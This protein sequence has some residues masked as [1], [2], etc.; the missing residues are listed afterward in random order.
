MPRMFLLSLAT[1]S[2]CATHSWAACQVQQ[3]EIPV[4]IVD[5]RPIA[6]L[7]LNGTEVPMLV[8]SGAF[9]SMLSPATATQLN[10]TVRRLPDGTRIEGYTGRIE[11]RRTRVEK[12]G[13]LG[14]ELPNV[15]FIVGGNEI[16]A[17][18]MG[19][20]GRNILA[21]ADTEYDLAHGVVRLSFPKG[22]CDKTN[23]A[24]WAGGAP[25]I[26]VPLDPPTVRADSAIRVPV[27]INGIRALALMDTGAPSTSLTLRLARRAGIEPGELKPYGR[28]GGAGDGRATSWTSP[29]A[30]FELGEQKVANTVLQVD[31]TSSRSHDMLVGL[32]Y[33]L[34]HRIYVS[35]LQGR[36]YATWN[37]GPIFALAR[38]AAGDDAGRYAALPQE[39]AADDAD[40]L[41]RRG[42]AAIAA[43]NHQR[44]LEDLNRACA[45][46]PTNADYL[47]TRAR[48]HLA[49]RQPSLALADLN[50]ALQLD[51]ALSEARLRRARL[52]AALGERAPA[53]E[54]L[55]QLD[56]ALP[57]SSAR[58]ADMAQ[59]YASLD[60]PAA[61]LKQF[62][63]W[64]NAHPRD[65]RLASVLNGRCWLR[66]RLNLDLPLALQDCKDAVDKDDGA[67]AHH[68]SLG[69]LYLR[70]GDAAQA[71][72]AFDRALKLQA[73][74]S[75][76][77]FSLYGRA[78]ALVRLNDVEG[79]ERDLAAARKLRP[80]I[81]D[82]I[83]RQGFPSA[84]STPPAA[85]PGS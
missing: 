74:P 82:E 34:S 40:A 59:V 55:A 51:P 18:I 8:D 23:F 26:E 67:A 81:D 64:V 41:A 76:L 60:Q 43:G 14:A 28:V 3:M 66:T 27:G 25:V 84:R 1:L 11:A 22:D 47:D 83:R 70:M 30:S 9:F 24:H 77:P 31:D 21:M 7:I 65:A 58:R 57:P 13:L 45:L 71:Q 49:M 78:M 36:M 75:A 80:R 50:Q 69:W 63:L 20:L 56:Q 62:D 48:L 46:A 73:P 39:V 33:F 52:R 2:L 6:T 85:T 61:A 17:G 53:Q 4:R 42:A 32:D 29:I 10:L 19:I 54:D 5:R 38:S 79:S 35:R 44:A 37:G 72:K 12:V 68:D 16:G 15:D